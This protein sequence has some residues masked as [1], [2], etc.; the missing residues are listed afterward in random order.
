MEA[1]A[2]PAVNVTEAWCLYDTLQI[3]KDAK[4]VEGYTT[5]RALS[6]LEEVP[7]FT[8]RNRSE[9]GLAYTNKDSKEALPFAFHIYSLGVSFVAAPPLAKLPEG[10]IPPTAEQIAEWD[11]G[12]IFEAIMFRHCG[13]TVKVREDERLA[14]T[15]ELAPPGTGGF[16][17]T[18]GAAPSMVQ[19]FNQ[20]WPD[21]ANRWKFPEPIRVPRNTIVKADLRFSGYA[22]T[23]LNRMVG[24]G[25]MDLY[26]SET[27]AKIAV[28]RCSM[29]RVSL[30]GKR[31]VQ[32]RGEL[33]Y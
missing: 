25:D 14:H 30:I 9:V 4:D 2:R 29:I 3:R 16:F 28:P 32:Q 20:G 8:T 26:N 5:Y 22:K 17:Y 31:E 24:P 13:V 15:V 21:L 33:H 7:F 12:R 27:Q 18:A 6:A 11:S 19:A 1:V 23:V 10:E